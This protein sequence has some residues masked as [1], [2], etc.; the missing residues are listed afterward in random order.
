[1]LGKAS[2]QQSQYQQQH[3]Q[4]VEHSNRYEYDYGRVD[5]ARVSQESD[6]KGILF[7]ADETNKTVKRSTKTLFSGSAADASNAIEDENGFSST[8]ILAIIQSKKKGEDEEKVKG[9]GVSVSISSTSSSSELSVAMDDNDHEEAPGI[10]TEPYKAYEPLKAKSDTNEE[11]TELEITHDQ[12]FSLNA[13]N[14]ITFDEGNLDDMEVRIEDLREETH[15][16]IA[17]WWE[18]T[19]KFW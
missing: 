19:L 5:S 6:E 8:E 17:H 3:Q 16:P 11:T 12:S 15:D 1:L 9:D 7:C 4:G 18:K 10:E 2:G 13:N 14:A